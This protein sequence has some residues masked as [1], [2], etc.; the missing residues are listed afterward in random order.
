MC[1]CSHLS[2]HNIVRWRPRQQP[3]REEHV[4]VRAQNPVVPAAEYGAISGALCTTHANDVTGMPAAR[5]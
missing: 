5:L 1:A 4:L 2:E 3:R